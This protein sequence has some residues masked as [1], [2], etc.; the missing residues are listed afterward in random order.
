MSLDSLN[1]HILGEANN[2]YITGYIKILDQ[3]PRQCSFLES[4]FS[5]R[6]VI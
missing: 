3:L 4:Y 6:T 1:D 2:N 5:Q